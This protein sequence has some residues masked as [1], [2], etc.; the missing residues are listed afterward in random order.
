MVCLDFFLLCL[1]KRIPSVG[2]FFEGTTS[3]L[4][5]VF[6]VSQQSASRYLAL[7]EDAG[8]IKKERVKQA[9][10]ISFTEEGV[11]VLKNYGHLLFVFLDSKKRASFRGE[12]VSGIGE[13]A[14]YVSKYAE[15]ISET[16][17][18]IPFHGT[19]NIRVYGGKPDI[20]SAST[21][22]VRGFS[23]DGR[24]FG[25]VT[26]TPINLKLY[27]KEIKCHVITPERTHHK[28]DLELISR[29]NLRRKYKIKDG[30]ETEIIFV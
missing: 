15:K 29:H 11:N 14:Y 12:I 5:E 18:Y 4:G 10:R 7:L 25:A 17:G 16:L 24:S 28:R 6:G 1:V 22:E 21:I 9:F 20:K 27:G 26:L 8:Y 23:H 13:G 3:D 30:D 2:G 19:L